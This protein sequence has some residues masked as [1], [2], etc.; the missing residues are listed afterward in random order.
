VILRA[1]V[2]L[3]CCFMVQMRRGSR[4]RGW[5]ETWNLRRWSLLH[6]GSL[7]SLAVL[8]QWRSSCCLATLYSVLNDSL[9]SR[10]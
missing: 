4:G 6:H 9:L 3:N 5:L 2:D 8:V 7:R 10:S 1:V